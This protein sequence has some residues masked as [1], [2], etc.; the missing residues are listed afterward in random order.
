MPRVLIIQAEMK[1]YRVPFFTKLHGALGQDGVELVV[2]YSAQNRKQATRGDG[3]ELPPEI[4]R[5]VPGY[6]FADRFLYQS[7]WR[8]VFSADLVIV[9]NENKYLINPFLLL[10]STL[11]LKTVAFWGLGPNMHP[12]RS[13]FS[14]WTKEKMV[15]SV[16][17]WFAYTETIADYL[18][19]HGMPAER[20][21]NVQNATDTVDLRRQL[22]EIQR[23]EA[24]QAKLAL[25]GSDS[26]KTGIYCGL[27]GDIKAIPMLIEA[28][29]L[30]R[31]RRPD[32]HL[33]IVGNGPDRKWLE[34]A[35][36]R[37]P[38]IHY[39]GS[40]FGRE[41]AM[42]YKI[43]DVFLL[44]GTAGLAIVD[45]F[46]AGLPL[47]ATQLP[48]HP[49]EI[50]YLRDGENGRLTAHNAAAFADAVVEVLSTPELMARLRRGAERAGSQY[51][52]EAMVENYRVG[53]TQCLV[54]TGV[55][56]RVPAKQHAYQEQKAAD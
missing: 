13:A 37:D 40:Q 48:T 45:S 50:S 22:S 54:R 52:I 2:A 32:F 53:I 3:A 55:V 30:V 29:R 47:I 7:L 35:I 16:D 17:W 5:K 31:L 27:L 43:A 14:E 44:A 38:W 56:Y 34:H 12:D 36:A 23:D 9:G 51:T 21:T 4:G 6:W 25:T 11:R 20:V 8:E 18:R 10:L 19:Q 46:A 28:A 39:M 42:L 33:V 41:S 15:T 1:H 24:A 49:P 26:S